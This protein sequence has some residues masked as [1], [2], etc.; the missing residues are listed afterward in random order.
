[1]RLLI[2][3]SGGREHALALRL[4]DE[5]DVQTIVCAPGNPGMTQVARLV[6][7]G[8]S[9]RLLQTIMLLVI[10]PYALLICTFWAWWGG[11]CPPV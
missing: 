7:L 8:R 10:G 11:Y 5:L 2:V 3:G 6:A 9:Y 4:A 1:M